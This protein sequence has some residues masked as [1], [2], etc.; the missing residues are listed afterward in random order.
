[1]AGHGSLVTLTEESGY[2]GA[3]RG[4]S[5]PESQASVFRLE[6]H[7]KPLFDSLHSKPAQ[8][9]ESVDAAD[10]KSVVRKDVRVQVPPL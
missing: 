7:H 2:L 1:M 4:E 3:D 9:V 5:D 10:L 8:V 6:F